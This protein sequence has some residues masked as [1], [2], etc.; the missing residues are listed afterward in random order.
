MHRFETRARQCAAAIL[1][2][3]DI[4]VVSHIDADGLTSAAIMCTALDR[5]GKDYSV[6]FVRQLDGSILGQIADTNPSITVFTDL[7]SGMLKQINNLGLN[8]VVS[9]HHIP[10]G[11]GAYHLNPHV[12]NINGAY[13][14]SGSGVTF[15]LAQ[16]MGRNDDLADLVVVGAVGDLQHIKQ[17]K[18]IGINRKIVKLGRETGAIHC[19][20]DLIMFGKQTRPVFKMLQYS[21]DPYLPGLSG[22]EEACIGFLKD[23]GLRFQGEN[24]LKWI[25]LEQDEK[26]RVTSGLIQYCMSAGIAVNK[27]QSLVGE[28]YT[29][30]REREGTETRDASEYSTLLNATARYDRAMTGLAVCRGDRDK[31]YENA[32]QLLA[33]HRRNLV[34]G[35]NLVKERGVI[36]LNNLQY[37]DAGNKIKDT[38]V[39]IVAGM[40]VSIVGS[41]KLPIIAF[42]DT[43]D[44]VKVSGRGNYDLVHK[45]LNLSAA[46]NSAAGSVNG[47]GGGHDIAAGATIPKPAK[48]EFIRILDEIIGTQLR[49]I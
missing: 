22:N 6:D 12:F 16:A 4:H 2:E 7:G 3:N 32:V 42:A 24:W 30:L 48:S 38:I 20:R 19:Q 41:R 37:F 21:S 5:A 33:V 35:I 17:G 8:A 1:K 13:E 43:E 18:L 10:S 23:M 14:I 29:L 45:G 44:G 9:D 31:E 40:S 36:T 25:D 39:G 11:E 27:I 26:Q 34:E 28:V 46:M 15:L 47:M 49:T